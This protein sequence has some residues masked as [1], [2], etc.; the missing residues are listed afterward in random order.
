MKTIITI[1]IILT[2]AAAIAQ[3]QP[4]LEPAPPAPPQA[5]SVTCDIPRDGGTTGCVCTGYCNG[6]KPGAPI[7]A[8]NAQCNAAVMLGTRSVVNGNGWNDGGTQ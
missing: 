2:A 4:C 3:N 5:T 7:A 1:I 6:C 8:T